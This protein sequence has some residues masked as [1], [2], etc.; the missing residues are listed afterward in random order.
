MSVYTTVEHAEL[1]N[2][3][4]QYSI[5]ELIDFQGISA[6]IEN[7]NYFVNTSKGKFVLTLFESLSLTE[8]PYFLNV[9]AF[10]AEHK[11]PSAHP[12]ARIDGQYITLFKNKPTALVN[13][14]PGSD[15]KIADLHHA[16]KLGKTLGYMHSIGSEFKDK[17]SN[18]RGS[19]WWQETILK[20]TGHIANDEIDLLNQELQY[21]LNFTH[22]HL[23]LGLTH[24]DL[25]KDNALWQGNKLT[26]IID[27]YYACNDV[28][29]YDVA[30]TANAWFSNPDGSLNL[31]LSQTFLSAYHQARPLN[32]YEKTAWPVMLRAAALR[33]WLS[34]LNDKVFP[35]DGEMTQTHDPKEFKRILLSH[36]QHNN[37]L[38]NVWP[39]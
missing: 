14:L 34:R 11:V 7:T 28:L 1:T 27:F 20:L 39:K 23:P 21:Q 25:F 35:K 37:Q 29:L 9:M 12:V 38:Q 31:E 30:V 19:D 10:L 18:S 33:F 13:C 17:R 6:G 26:G 2:L 22:D 3:L 36:I 24:A 4:K 15:V 16:N 32:Q 8:L 5:G